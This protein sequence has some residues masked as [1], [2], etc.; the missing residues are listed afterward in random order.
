MNDIIA[1]IAAITHVDNICRAGYR[2]WE[3]RID[4]EGGRVGHWQHGAFETI[5]VFDSEQELMEGLDLVQVRV[6]ERKRERFGYVA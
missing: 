5:F 1:K 2:G 6:E 3:I 4:S